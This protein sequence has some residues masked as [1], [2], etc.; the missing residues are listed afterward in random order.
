M[1]DRD[2]TLIGHLKDAWAF[3]TRLLDLV[4]EQVKG[5]ADAPSRRM[6]REHARLTKTQCQRIQ[7]RL[8]L[9]G[10]HVL[11][12]ESGWFSDRL[13]RLAVEVAVMD[14]WR[15]ESIQRLITSYGIKQLECNMYRSLLDL[16]ESTDDEATASL[17][18]TSLE[19]EEAT[20]R[21]LLFCIGMAT[22]GTE[23]KSNAA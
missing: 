5:C 1:Q 23:S 2:T 21:R 7:R 9:L 6:Y 19:E 4:L 3:E 13:K 14:V 22:R 15:D 8:E 11:G 18:R 10:E 16:A 20:A 17:A 12:E